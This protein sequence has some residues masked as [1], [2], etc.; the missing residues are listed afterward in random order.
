MFPV[1]EIFCRYVRMCIVTTY[2]FVLSRMYARMLVCLYV[3]NMPTHF[4][5]PTIPIR[6]ML[7]KSAHRQ[8]CGNTKYSSLKRCLQHS[9]VII[10]SFHGAIHFFTTHN[11]KILQCLRHTT[12]PRSQNASAHSHKQRPKNKH[13]HQ[14]TN[15]HSVARNIHSPY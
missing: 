11:N 13:T 5:E 12:K 9:H 2:D 1:T 14:H 10:L 7:E 15:S 4:D 3:C 6:E 8:V